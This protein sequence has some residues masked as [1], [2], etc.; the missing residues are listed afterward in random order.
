LTVA[1]TA[2]YLSYKGF[3]DNACRY[4]GPYPFISAGA[5]GGWG[6]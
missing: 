4:A 5:I 1:I 2:N 6:G 3:T